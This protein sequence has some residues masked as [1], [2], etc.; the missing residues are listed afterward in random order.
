[1]EP[2]TALHRVIGDELRARIT[3]GRLPIGAA[4]PSE[5]ELC[6]EFSVSRGPVRQAL[7]ALRAEGIIAGGQGA[8]AHVVGSIPTQSMTSFLSFSEWA[9][10]TNRTPG[11]RTV[12]LAK[13][14]ANQDVAL[15]LGVP[16]GELVVEIIRLRL[17]DEVPV[18]VERTAFTLDAGR[19]LFDFDTDSGS[20]F[21]HLKANDVE[22][23][24]ARHTFDAIG[25]GEVDAELLDVPVGSPLLRER[26]ITST[27]SGVPVEYSDDHYLPDQVTFTINNTAGAA[28]SVVRLIPD[29]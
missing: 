23:V 12:E 29:T 3:D 19:H 9:H 4:V 5:A 14:A 28:N 2:R 6:R 26:R 20:I 24:A 10:S 25:A 21:A 8:V 11:Q 1:M 22:L 17:L 13:R 15:N 27:G 16:V 18:M 7:S